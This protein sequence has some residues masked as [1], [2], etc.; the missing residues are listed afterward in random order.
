MFLNAIGKLNVSALCRI[1]YPAEF[2]S[3]FDAVVYILYAI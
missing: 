1:S 2:S 3:L